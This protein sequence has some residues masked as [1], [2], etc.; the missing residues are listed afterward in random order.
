[1]SEAI[2]IVGFGPVGRATARL[3]SGQGRA[4]S[5][6]QRSP[7]KSLPG[8]A[9]FV[10]C[11]ALD[12]DAVR[13]AVAGAS[14]VVLAVGFPYVG[15]VWREAW[16]RTMTNFVEACAAAGARLIFVDNLYMYGPRDAPLTEATTLADFGVKPAARAAATRIWMA[17]SEAGRARIAA[18]RAPDFYGPGVGQSWL[19][20]TGFGALAKGKAATVIGSPDTPHDF[21]YVPD[22]ARAVATL[23]DAPDD[24]FGQAWHVPC[25]PIRTPREIFA[26]GAAALGV[27]PRV[28]GLP[29]WSLGA[30]GLIVPPLREMREMSFQWDRPYRVDSSRFGKRFWSDATPFEVGAPAAALSF[31]DA[32]ATN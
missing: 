27:P 20:D 31:R 11:D 24:A 5:V 14:Q 26:L 16:P 17:A 30:I 2:T 10:R 4:V 6:A 32:P 19:G 8:G 22:F 21:A 23:V 18:L 15:A 9:T 1:M 3:L 29:P 7:P 25:A 28:R 12:A 13:A